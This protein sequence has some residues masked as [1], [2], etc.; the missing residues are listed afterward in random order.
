MHRDRDKERE[1]LAHFE[2]IQKFD[3]AQKRITRG[4]ACLAC[5]S[6]PAFRHNWIP[7]QCKHAAEKEA[8]DEWIMPEDNTIETW[9]PYEC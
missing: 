3:E 7:G 5:E 8:V 1:I 9:P 2:S 4:E 6:G